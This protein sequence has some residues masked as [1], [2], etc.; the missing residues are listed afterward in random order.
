M[1]FGITRKEDLVDVSGLIDDVDAEVVD[2]VAEAFDFNGKQKVSTCIKV[3]LKP[4][5]VEETATE[6]YRVGDPNSIVADPDGLGCSPAQGSTAKGYNSKSKAGK[7]IDSLIDI[8]GDKMPAKFDGFRG[9]RFHW[10]RKPFDMKG[11]QREAG[12]RDV[13]ILL[14]T[15]LVGSATVAKV[16]KGAAGGGVPADAEDLFKAALEALGGT[17]TPNAV[18]KQLFKTGTKN[19]HIKDIVKLT[20]NQDWLAA[21]ERPWAFDG[22]NLQLVG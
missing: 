15:K 17:A 18:G 4:D 11:I 2:F 20:M 10:N 7:L 3:V 14:P 6:Y 19:P 8:L 1:S 16:A 5:G 9:M 12:A 22:E 13:T 21:D